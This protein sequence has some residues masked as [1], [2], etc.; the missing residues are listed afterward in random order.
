MEYQKVR[1]A[2]ENIKPEAY[3]VSV[4]FPLK[5]RSLERKRR[6]TIENFKSVYQ[7]R[8]VI[9]PEDLLEGYKKSLED[10]YNYTQDMYDLVQQYKAATA[11]RNKK[12]KLI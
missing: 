11:T 3:D 2:I 7:D 12:N 6:D 4:I 9:N 8:S 1:Q 10:S 5:L